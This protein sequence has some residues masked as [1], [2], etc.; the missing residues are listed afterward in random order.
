MRGNNMAMKDAPL[1]NFKK[2]PVHEVAMSMVFEPIIGFQSRHIG[3][4]WDAFKGRYPQSSEH[5]PIQIPIEQ[6]GPVGVPQL[7]L[8]LVPQPDMRRQWFVADGEAELV[9]I[10]VDR[11]VRNWRKRE[12]N[13]YPRFGPLLEG[14]RRDWLTFL[15]VLKAEKLPVPKVLQCEVD[16]I[17]HIDESNG[18]ESFAQ[19]GGVFQP[20]A[21]AFSDGYLKDREADSVSAN[22]S[23][24]MVDADNKPIGRLRVALESRVTLVKPQKPLLR[25]TL[26]ARG[27][28]L[29]E[30][31]DGA[32]AFF[33]QG[34]EWIVRGFASAT[35]K[36]AHQIWERKDV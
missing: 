14:V 24:P 11:F 31:W 15:E 16:Y 23:Y 29:G 22:F 3:A 19:A 35:T 7:R 17:N 33:E 36:R 4:L 2:P 21:G 32:K 20:L 5:P 1:P 30:G 6:F 18:L 8:E 26:S 13:E 10:Q 12:N 25:L 34:R 27:R 28:P 9:Q